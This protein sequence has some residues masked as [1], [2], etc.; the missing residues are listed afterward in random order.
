[1][2]TAQMPPASVSLYE[3]TTCS[4]MMGGTLHP[5]GSELTRRAV[6]LGSLGPGDHVLDLGC[7]SGRTVRYLR[8]LGSPAFGLDFSRALLQQ[9]LAN[10]RTFPGIQGDALHLPIQTSSLEAV[11]CE[12]SL[13][14]FQD[15]SWVLTEIHRVLQQT[16]VLILTDLYARVPDQL[17]E[18]RRLVPNSCLANAFAQKELWDILQR[19]GFSLAVWEDH[20]EALSA[21]CAGADLNTLINPESL[22]LDPFDLV[23]AVSR[24]KISYFLCVAQKK[25]KNGN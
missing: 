4:P 17:S 19:S 1:M 8:G 25:K 5:G 15:L 23:L 12:C 18:I 14:V 6:E 16:G 20:A 7:G 21:F 3:K 10:S 24:A 11:I 2:T 9:E 13:S 22:S